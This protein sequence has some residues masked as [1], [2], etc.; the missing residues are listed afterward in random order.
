MFCQYSLNGGNVTEQ[1]CLYNM[2]H[3]RAVR[4]GENSQV[5]NIQENVI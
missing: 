3:K 4:V 1:L 5:L 2:F